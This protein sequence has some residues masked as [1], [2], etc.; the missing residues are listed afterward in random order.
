MNITG[1][2]VE[3]NPM[4]NGHLK[5]INETK[6][7]TNCDGL[8][9]IMSGNFVQRGLPSI[10]DKWT[11]AKIALLNGVDLVI[12]L[13]TLY[14][15]SS[16]EFFSFG[17]INILN[18]LNVVDNICF[19]SEIGST[20]NLIKLSQILIDEP[21]EYKILLKKYLHQGVSY[22]KARNMALKDFNN[23]FNFLNLPIDT[24]LNSS[25]NILGIEYIKSLLK[26]N[27]CI[28]PYTIKREGADYKD[29]QLHSKYSSASSIRKFLKKTNDINELSNHLPYECFDELKS[30]KDKCFSFSLEDSMIKHI[31]YK[32]ALGEKNIGNIPDVSEG[33]DNRIY[34]FL[35][36]NLNF[37]ETVL[38]IKSKRYIYSRISRIL[39]QYFIGFEYYD[40]LNLRKEPP[41]YA[42]ILGFN[43]KGAEIL[44]KIKK[45]SNIN[46]YTKIPKSINEDTLKIDIQSTRIY[47]LINSNL[48][49]NEDYLKSPIIIK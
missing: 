25:N 30:L 41:S 15:L 27:S 17:A 33:L 37:N 36:Q 19:G 10:L 34:K 12:E 22:A 3:Y 9:A 32:Y 1:I 4:H 21:Y 6:K 14:S 16:A 44:N 40:I 35:E 11:K 24:L 48:S 13:P 38:S 47:S 42:R 31:R 43:R 49:F 28:K 7:I 18:S 20:E 29:E 23:K 8:I 46:L 26:L 2:I 5:H 45:N 39:C